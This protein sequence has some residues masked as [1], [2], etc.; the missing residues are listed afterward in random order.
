MVSAERITWLKMLTMAFQMS[1]GEE[2]EVDLKKAANGDCQMR[3]ISQVMQTMKPVYTVHEG[4]A[5]G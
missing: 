1:Y 2:A 3:M 4:G 5:I